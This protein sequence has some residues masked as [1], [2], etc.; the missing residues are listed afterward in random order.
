M[1]PVRSKKEL[2][3][4]LEKQVQAFLEHGGEIDVVERGKSGLPHEK[5]WINP[6]KSGDSEQAQTRTPIPE[7]VAAIEA[8]KRAKKKPAPKIRKPEKQ[9][10]LDDFGEPVRWVWKDS[11]G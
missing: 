7:V 2:H 9:W 5:P 11:R 3:A 10:I 8:R 6:F 1:K 4:D